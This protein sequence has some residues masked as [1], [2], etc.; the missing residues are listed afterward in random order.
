MSTIES[1]E[2]LESYPPAKGKNPK[3]RINGLYGLPEQ[4][5]NFV[6]RVTKVLKGVG[7][8]TLQ[9]RLNY[10]DCYC[11]KPTT[12][13]AA[14]YRYFRIRRLVRL[15]CGSYRL[16]VTETGDRVW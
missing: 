8:T 7:N 9:S 15:G 16:S 10:T 6:D 3:I 14:A 1:G 13:C 2:L 12:P 4:G 5:K 11:K